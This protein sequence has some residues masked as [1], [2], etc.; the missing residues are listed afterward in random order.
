[1]LRT[2]LRSITLV[3]PLWQGA[4]LAKYVG[5]RHFPS[6]AAGQVVEE[7]ALAIGSLKGLWQMFGQLRA[8]SAFATAARGSVPANVH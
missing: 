3:Y 5:W 6:L 2:L 1:M 7:M 4:R 8:Q